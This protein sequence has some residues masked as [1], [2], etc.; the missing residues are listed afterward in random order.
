MTTR[1]RVPSSNVHPSFASFRLSSLVFIFPRLPRI[2]ILGT[3]QQQSYRPY[4]TRWYRA[5]R[6]GDLR[7]WPAR[8][9]L[10][11]DAAGHGVRP[12]LRSARHR[13]LR[14]SS[15]ERGRRYARR[16][17]VGTLGPARHSGR[18]R[19]RDGGARPVAGAVDRGA[20]PYRPH[21]HAQLGRHGGLRPAPRP[22]GHLRSHAAP[23]RSL[24]P[25]D[26]ALRQ[27]LQD[28]AAVAVSGRPRGGGGGPR[29]GSL[30]ITVFRKLKELSYRSSYSHR[31]R[32]YTLT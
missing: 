12:L 27:Q 10:A 2:A 7:R 26:G 15:P 18:R 31:G 29:F 6:R 30:D 32:Y 14:G 17:A 23:L 22:A 13:P 1:C 5:W 24:G 9:Q 19:G 16:R 20:L 3:Q 8:D 11:R 28:E 21:L 25:R 4:R